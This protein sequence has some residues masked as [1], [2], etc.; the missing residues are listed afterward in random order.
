MLFLARFC[1]NGQKYDKGT[2]LYQLLV[3]GYQL[4]VAGC[5][6][7]ILWPKNKSAP[8]APQRK[9]APFFLKKTHLSTH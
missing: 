3:T 9:D 5:Q 4:P 6:L 2:R 1:L 7:W 8:S